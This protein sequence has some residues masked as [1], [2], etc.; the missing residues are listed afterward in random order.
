M[1]PEQAAE[2]ERCL[3]L[4]NHTTEQTCA[5]DARRSNVCCHVAA[6]MRSGHFNGATGCAAHNFAEDL[7]QCKPSLIAVASGAELD[8]LVGALPPT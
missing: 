5:R 8:L 1:L 3:G 4:A 7:H 2:F 6:A